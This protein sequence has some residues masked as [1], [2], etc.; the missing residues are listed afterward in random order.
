MINNITCCVCFM[1]FCTY[2]VT[3]AYNLN[4]KHQIGENVQI[5]CCSIFNS[6]VVYICLTNLFDW[7]NKNI[8]MFRLLCWSEWNTFNV[9]VR[10]SDFTINSFSFFLNGEY[11]FAIIPIKWSITYSKKKKIYAIKQ[12][13]TIKS[14]TENS[15]YGRWKARRR[16]DFMSIEQRTRTCTSK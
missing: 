11:W 14:R 1:S 16:F 4:L 12:K 3:F 8:H 10:C 13:K 2:L 15:K 5:I 6:I 7:S 9:H